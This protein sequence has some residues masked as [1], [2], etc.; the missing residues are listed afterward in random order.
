MKVALLGGGNLGIQYAQNLCKIDNIEV[1]GVCDIQAEAAHKLADLCKAPA[2]T[3]YEEMMANTEPDLICMCLPTF[4]QKEYMLKA[5]GQGKSIL[6]EAPMAATV[7]EAEEIMAAAEAKGV[8]IFVGHAERFSPYYKN[9]KDKL[10]KGLIG[11][12]GVVHIQHSG[13]HPAGFEDWYN[14]ESKSGGII[15]QRFVHDVFLMRWMLGEVRSVYAMH[16]TVSGVDYALVTLRFRNDAIV[17]LAGHWGDPEP[18]RC[19][20]E[21]AGN[22]GAIRY[23]SR[24]TYSFELKKRQGPTSVTTGESPMLHSPYYYQLEHFFDCMRAGTA[25]QMNAGDAH[26]AYQIAAGDAHQA[27]QITEAAIRSA[28]TGKPVVWEGLNHG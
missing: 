25:P 18:Y 27:L 7:A 1:T 13:P 28:K 8:Q 23:D 24:N 4:V 9:M 21:V 22:K 3:S 10:T 11:A 26:Q 5:I 15:L 19:R 17:N 20:I 16:R 2:F 12:A 6:C 14:D